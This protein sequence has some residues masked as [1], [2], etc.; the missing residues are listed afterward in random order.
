MTVDEFLS[1]IQ[2]MKNEGKITG[3]TQFVTYDEWKE[4]LY[5]V[6]DIDVENGSIII[7]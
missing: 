4:K 6:T 3:K 7:F 1:K 5:K 2:K